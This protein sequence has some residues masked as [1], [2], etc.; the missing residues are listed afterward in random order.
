MVRN[1]GGAVVTGAAAGAVSGTKPTLAC[2][3]PGFVNGTGLHAPVTT[4]TVTATA[5]GG[6][7]SYTGYLWQ[8]VGASAETWAITSPTSAST[9]F[10]C[11][12]VLDGSIATAQFTCTVT[13][14]GSNTA[15]SNAL[16]AHAFARGSLS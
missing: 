2:T 10:A 8:Q 15:V 11:D 3:V 7:G 4:S 9:A 1:R 6:T 12:T 5:T 14:S 16:E 13:D